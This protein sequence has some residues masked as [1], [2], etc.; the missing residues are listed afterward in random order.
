[1]L[2]LGTARLFGR[3]RDQLV[4]IYVAAAALVVVIAVCSPATDLF[5]K[6]FGPRYVVRFAY[7]FPLPALA[8]LG[9]SLAIVGRGR[10]RSIVFAAGLTAVALYAAVLF[11]G[12][13]PWKLPLTADPLPQTLR[14]ELESLEPLLRNRVV[15]TNRNT[16][17]V[18]PYFTGAFVA[19][20]GFRHHANRWVFDSRRKVGTLKIL[21]GRMSAS[22]LQRYCDRYAVDFVLLPSTLRGP[23]RYLLLTQQFRSRVVGEKFVLLERTPPG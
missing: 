13:E 22:D 16:A 4:P 9:L 17:Y 12:V 19:W 2:L 3:T 20:N 7:V 15:V 10:V 5:V 1:V 14:P 18:L 11:R 8:G 23:I 6:I 21:S